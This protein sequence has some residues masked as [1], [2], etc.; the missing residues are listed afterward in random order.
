MEK[1]IDKKY[2]HLELVVD[3]KNFRFSFGKDI[4]RVLGEPDYVCIRINK[5]YDS[6][7]VKPCESKDP[8]SFKVPERLLT[9]HH[10]V[11]RVNSKSFVQ[12]LL[13]AN[14][15]EIDNTYYFSGIYCPEHNSVIIPIILKKD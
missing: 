13:L 2:D 14:S 3:T 6:I 1:E 11:F 4:I 9:N 15:I 10:C 7:L 8:M 5:N 12:S